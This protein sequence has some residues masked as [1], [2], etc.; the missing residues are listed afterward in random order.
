M[1]L[2][3]FEYVKFDKKV[4]TNWAEHMKLVKVRTNVSGGMIVGS[5]FLESNISICQSMLLFLFC[6]GILVCNGQLLQW[7]M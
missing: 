2:N 5:L 1:S 3:T 4:A 6:L 7:V